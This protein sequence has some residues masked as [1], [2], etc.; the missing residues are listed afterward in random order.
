MKKW[1]YYFLIGLLFV[2]FI[3][4]SNLINDF[5]GVKGWIEE[6]FKSKELIAAN[7]YS[8]IEDEAVKFYGECDY[9]SELNLK[10]Y[11]TPISIEEIKW[12]INSLSDNDKIKLKSI[13]KEL[14]TAKFK[15][16]NYSYNCLENYL[17]YGKYESKNNIGFDMLEHMEMV[18][19]SIAIEKQ[20]LYFQS[21]KLSLEELIN[22]KKEISKKENI[23]M[24]DELMKNRYHLMKSLLFEYELIYKSSYFELFNEKLNFNGV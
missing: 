17:A 14:L 16:Y 10:S 3:D 18:D 20:L 22:K 8:Q 13:I 4:F 15:Y 6:K 1:H 12:K 2:S 7:K 5:Y 23:K 9:V 24:V 21:D 19:S 11:S